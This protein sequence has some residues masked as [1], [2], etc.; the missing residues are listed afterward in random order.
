MTHQC[1]VDDC[2]GY[3]Q[4]NGDEELYCDVYCMIGGGVL[5]E[6]CPEGSDQCYSTCEYG[7]DLEYCRFPAAY[8]DGYEFCDT[9]CMPNNGIL[10]GY[11]CKWDNIDNNEK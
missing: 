5:S 2:T 10:D 3:E 1:H 4:D 11:D 8:D 7:E 6:Y 9:Y